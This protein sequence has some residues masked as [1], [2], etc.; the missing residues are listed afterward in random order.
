MYSSWGQGNDS[1]DFEPVQGKHRC[2]PEEIGLEYYSLE[3]EEAKKSIQEPAFFKP[4]SAQIDWFKTYSSKLWCFDEPLDQRGN[5]D[6]TEAKTITVNVFRCDPQVRSTC[7][8]DEEI[9]AFISNKFILILENN[10]KFKQEI[11]SE[12]RRVEKRSE[13]SFVPID[14]DLSVELIK[15]VEIFEVTF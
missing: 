15:M 8:S 4:Y 3:D 13:L 5:Y 6:T 11:Y 1:Y 12:E 9:D 10:Y 7:K 14:P 2:S